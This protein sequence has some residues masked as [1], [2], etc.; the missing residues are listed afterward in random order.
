MARWVCHFV[1]SSGPS[2]VNEELTCL[3]IGTTSEKNSQLI[4][5]SAKAPLLLRR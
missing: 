2:C 1:R 4:N 3:E 5:L